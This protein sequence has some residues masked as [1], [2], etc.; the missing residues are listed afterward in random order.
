MSKTIIVM[1]INLGLVLSTN[2]HASQD[3]II[4]SEGN[5]AI[6]IDNVIE[7]GQ[8]K[9]KIQSCFY[10]HAKESFE[11]CKNIGDKSAYTRS[12]IA[13]ATE[14]YLKKQ[15]RNRVLMTAGVAVG[16]GL[17]VTFAVPALVGATAFVGGV[18]QTLGAAAVAG[19][20]SFDVA[21][22]V[23]AGG[24]LG[25]LIGIGA[26]ISAYIDE[27]GELV[28]LKDGVELLELSVET[29][30]DMVLS[31]TDILKAVD[32]LRQILS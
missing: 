21:G 6:K 9:I 28:E 14:A 32:S 10:N 25:S 22:A 19:A 4:P 15:R 26:G 1:L 5:V 2:L 13:V 18:G 31:E 30:K 16:V 12:E 29:M 7:Q 3:N 11:R 23:M 27:T 8:E 20:T 24:A 17:A